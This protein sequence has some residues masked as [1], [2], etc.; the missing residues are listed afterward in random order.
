M[1][2]AGPYTFCI[3]GYDKEKTKQHNLEKFLVERVSAPNLLLT[4]F[5]T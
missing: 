3:S 5:I 4:C 1:P 2:D